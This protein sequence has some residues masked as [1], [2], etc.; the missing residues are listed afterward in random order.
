MWQILQKN[1]ESE[2]MKI[3]E[4]RNR[5]PIIK[6]GM[7]YQATC[8][9]GILPDVGVQAIEDVKGTSTE[10]PEVNFDN[11]LNAHEELKAEFA[12][13]INA[14]PGEIDIIAQQK[15]YIVFI[16]V[17]TKSSLDFGS[18]EESI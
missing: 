4:Y 16:E 11:F 14:E 18:P 10:I 13:I 15:D 2:H 7:N 6:R 3:E 1:E 12:K 9:I 17:R 8:G 5:F